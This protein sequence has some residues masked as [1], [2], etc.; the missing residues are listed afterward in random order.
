MKL[1]LKRDAQSRDESTTQLIAAAETLLIKEVQKSL[2]KEPKFETWRKQF[3]NFTDHQGLMRCTGRLAEAELSTSSKY[4][5][6]LDKGHH[7]TSLIVQ[8]SH[9]RDMHGAVKSTLTELRARFWIVQGRQFVRKLLYCVSYAGNLKEGHIERHQ[10]GSPRVQSERES[11]IRIH[12][13]R[14]CRPSLRHNSHW[15]STESLDLPLHMCY[16]SYPFGSSTK[17]H[18]L[19]VLE[20]P[21]KIYRPPRQSVDDG[22]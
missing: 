10:H 2:S 17:P 19:S 18:S 9:K 3:G 13:S 14:F 15:P 8:D 11:T 21:E 7:M 6:L 16:Q 20:K 1:L 4:P 12:W 22:L 5:I